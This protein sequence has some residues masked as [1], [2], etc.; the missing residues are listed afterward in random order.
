[1][2]AKFSSDLDIAVLLSVVKKQKIT[3]KRW[4]SLIRNWIIGA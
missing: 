4:Q 1:M 2:L 3:P